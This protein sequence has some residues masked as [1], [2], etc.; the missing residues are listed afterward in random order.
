MIARAEKQGFGPWCLPDASIGPFDSSSTYEEVSNGRVSHG[1]DCG[2][3]G[4]SL[5]LGG[6]R[7]ME[8]QRPLGEK[9]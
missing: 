7:L 8:K 2:L 5:Y 4:L 1:V 3:T 9:G 6:W